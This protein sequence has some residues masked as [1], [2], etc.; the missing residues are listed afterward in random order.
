MRDKWVAIDWRQVKKDKFPPHCVL[1]GPQLFQCHQNCWNFKL[2]VASSFNMANIIRLGTY[3]LCSSDHIQCTQL[4]SQSW[5]S[6]VPNTVPWYMYFSSSIN[7]YQHC[8]LLSNKPVHQSS[9]S[10]S[11]QIN[12][13]GQVR[14]QKVFNEVGMAVPKRMYINHLSIIPTHVYVNMGRDDWN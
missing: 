7:H 14:L 2:W 12:M 5:T 11:D 10:G 3:I 6:F 8:C 4:S 9:Y 13:H 1:N